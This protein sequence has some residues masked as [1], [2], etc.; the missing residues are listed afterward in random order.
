MAIQCPHPR[1]R[2]GRFIGYHIPLSFVFFIA[3]VACGPTVAQDAV[4]KEAERWSPRLTLQDAIDRALAASPGLQAARAGIAS[5]R[6]AE[7]QAKLLPNPEFSLE[8]ENFKGSGPYRDLDSAELTYGVSQNIELGGKR[9]ARRQAATAERKAAEMASESA[10]LDLIRA[11]KVAYTQAAAAEH[12]LTLALELESIAKRVLY[13]VTERVKAAREPEIQ[14]SKAE[15]AYA[16][17]SAA[18]Q[19]AA[20][21]CAAK[22]K[23][24]SRF[25]REAAFPERLSVEYIFSFPEPEALE[26]YE[27]RL[28]RSPDI[29]RFGRLTEAREAELKLARAGVVP[30]PKITV[31]VRQFRDT[32]EQALVAGVSIPFPVFN[33]NQGEIARS[34]AEIVRADNEHRQAEIDQVGQ[35]TDAWSQWQSAWVEARNLKETILPQAERAF[36][37]TLEGYRAGRFSYLEVLDAQ[38]TLFEARVEQVDALIRL[39]LA[40][41]DVER[42]AAIATPEQKEVKP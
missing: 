41:A 30:D 25:W 5:A 2:M 11:V 10:R 15:V 19:R 42:L 3:I 8:V 21:T 31:G 35:L 20:N 26:I 40:R 1:Q 34:G 22:R 17:S 28:A 6:G 16:A 29:A 36:R 39:H 32:D 9:S 27:A 7:R 13:N 4:R 24:L 33:W 23:A 12:S 38:R 14:Q 18:R 37:L